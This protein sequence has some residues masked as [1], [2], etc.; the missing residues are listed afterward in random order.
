VDTGEALRLGIARFRAGEFEEAKVQF[1]EALRLDPTQFEATEW[2]TKTQAEI[3]KRRR[4]T[5]EI[6]SIQQAFAQRDYRGAL[7]RLYRVETPAA[8]R[9]KV[10]RWIADC[11]YDWG[12]ESLQ[13]G[14][15]E[16]A[17]K[18]FK[19]AR[20]ARSD[21]R[22]AAQHLE[23]LVRYK[24]RPPDAALQAYAARLTLRPLD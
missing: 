23:V 12:V 13:G 20:D 3:D 22:E 8:E 21:D 17:Q 18:N 5:T 24:D 2:A 14:R 11:W 10:D 19:E 15:I 16:D 4:Y 1:D 9:K 7:Y 6:A